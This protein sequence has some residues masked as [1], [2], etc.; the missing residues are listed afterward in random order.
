VADSASIPGS[1]RATVQPRGLKI[2]KITDNTASL[3]LLQLVVDIL[4]PLDIPNSMIMAAYCFLEL[5]DHY[6]ERSKKY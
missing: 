4:R 6:P 2:K 1:P 3:A 5:S